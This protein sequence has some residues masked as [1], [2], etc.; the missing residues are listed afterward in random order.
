[1]ARTKISE[2]SATPANNTDIDSINIAEGCAPSGINDA[3]RELMAQLKDFQVG[4]AGDPVTVGGVLTVTAGAVGTPA[5]TTAGDTN[6]GIFF[7]AADTIAFAEGGAEAMRIDSSGNLGL[8]VTPS[9][10]YTPAG[11]KVMQIG[12]GMSFDSGNDFRARIASNAFVNSGGDFKYVN[13]GFA[14]NYNQASGQHQ[15]YT[16]PSGTAGNA[17]TFT[18]AMTLAQDGNNTYVNF[19]CT[20]L[21]DA[22]QLY[23][24]F[25]STSSYLAI[26]TK[27]SGT[28]AERVRIDSSGNL[29]VGYTSAASGGKLVVNGLVYQQ[30][31]ANG[32]SGTP[33]LNGGYICGPNDSTIYAGIRF[34]NSYLS[35]NASQLAFYVTNTTGSA[36][37]AGRFDASG[38]L[39][40]GTTSVIGGDGAKVNI[41]SAASIATS[42]PSTATSAAIGFHN[43]NGRIGYIGVSGSATSYNTSSDYRLKNTI[44]PMTG[45]LAK[46]A[47]LKPVTYK[48]NASGSDGEGFIAHELAEICPSAVSGQK[49][50][51]DEN[52]N[53]QYQGVDT[54]FLV[55]TLTA[56]IQEQQVLITTLTQRIT[57]LEA[58]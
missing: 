16:A 49:D 45:A 17:I 2:F 54:S 55:A 57:A 3:I 58:K 42:S 50:A 11:Y 28:L 14:S 46:I 36:Y 24:G 56:A 32:T 20:G 7:P 34:L 31:T 51:I 23:T 26:G 8:G 44:A 27:N 15:W 39:L 12:P 53:P 47:Q 38:N 33:L 29:L 1:M 19:G 4:S 13:T 43:P 22:V 18:Q 6:T 48:W 10:W 21:A 41:S 35:N 9:A 37:E 40:V 25:S 30:Q 52:G 5:I